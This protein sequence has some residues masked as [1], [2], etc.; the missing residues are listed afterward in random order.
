MLGLK[1]IFHALQNF[2]TKRTKFWSA[3]VNGRQ[4]DGA[5]DAIRHRAGTRDLQKV[6]AS[7]MKVKLKHVCSIENRGKITTM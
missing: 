7:R 6:A 2:Q 3:M 1:N 4:A 5:Q